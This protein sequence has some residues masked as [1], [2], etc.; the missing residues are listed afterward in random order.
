MCLISWRSR[1][2]S[3]VHSKC[4]ATIKGTPTMRSVATPFASVWTVVSNAVV[5]TTVWS[6]NVAEM[7]SRMRP[8]FV[9]FSSVVFHLSFACHHVYL[10]HTPPAAN[11]WPALACW[12]KNDKL[13]CGLEWQKMYSLAQDLCSVGSE[14]DSAVNLCDWSSTSIWYFPGVIC[15]RGA[16]RW[17]KGYVT[18]IQVL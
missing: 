14:G 2:S 8:R 10:N 11:K 9:R 4:E 13:S 3:C 5:W 18:S 1:E 6:V 12:I 7:M 16:F 17:S 15:L